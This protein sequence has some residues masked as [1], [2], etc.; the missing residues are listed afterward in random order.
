[1]KKNKPFRV[2]TPEQYER[3]TPERR[4]AYIDE[5]IRSKGLP[6]RP[7]RTPTKMPRRG[8]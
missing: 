3:L 4:L 8:R 6:D 1:M 7:A 5:A 2:L